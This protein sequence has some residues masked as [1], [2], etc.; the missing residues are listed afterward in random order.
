V[1]GTVR[2]EFLLGVLCC[3][4]VLVWA[5]VDCPK[6]TSLETATLRLVTDQVRDLQLAAARTEA[7]LAEQ[8]GVSTG[9][10]VE[11]EKLKNRRELEQ[12]ARQMEAEVR[13]PHKARIVSSKH[14]RVASHRHTTQSRTPCELPL[15]IHAPLCAL[16]LQ[17]ES[18]KVAE[19]ERQRAFF[20]EGE[21]RLRR[22]LKDSEGRHRTAAARLQVC[23]CHLWPVLVCRGQPWP[24]LL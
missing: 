5:E 10:R 18:G 24:A 7:K 23:A 17:E 14:T 9:L 6:C 21:E 3:V 15:Q 8:V 1:R 13:K 2:T 16:H 19:L 20:A 22:E 4:V 11:L 12:A